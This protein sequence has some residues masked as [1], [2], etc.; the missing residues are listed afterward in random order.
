MAGNQPSCYPPPVDA[1]PAPIPE[2]LAAASDEEVMR[3]YSA[4]QMT[5]GIKRWAEIAATFPKVDAED[6]RRIAPGQFIPPDTSAIETWRKDTILLVRAERIAKAAI[7][8]WYA[9]KPIDFINHWGVTYDPRSAMRKGTTSYP[10]LLLFE[11][12]RDFV[13]F[14]WALLNGEEHALIEKSRDM[15]ATWVCALFSVWLWLTSSAAVGWGSRKEELVD[16]IGDPDSIFE[17]IRMAIRA[18]PDFL[19]PQGLSQ[20]DHLTFMKCINPD[21]GASITGECGDNIGRGGRSLI[22]FKDE[23]AHYARPDLIEASLGDNTNVQVDFSSVNGLGNVF[24]RRREAGEIWEPGQP[25]VSGKANVFILDWHDH[26]G[27]DEEWYCTRRDKAIREGLLHKFKQEVDRDYAASVEGLIIKAEW[28]KAAIDAHKKLGFDDSG[29]YSGGLDVSDGETGDTNALAIFKGVVL[30]AADDWGSVDTGAT[31]RRAVEQCRD[32][33]IDLQY[34]CIGVGSGVK[35]EANRLADTIGDDGLPLLPEGISLIPWSASA[36]VLDP[37]EPV[38]PDDRDSPTNKDMFLNLK[39]QAW[40]MVAR[41]FEKT[42]R[43][44]EEGIDYDPAELIS[45]DSTIPRVRQ[46]EK[47]LSQPTIK[48]HTNSGKMLIDKKP[49][50]TKS[51]NLGDAIIMA[52]FPLTGMKPI[53]TTAIPEFQMPPF[54]VPPFWPRAFAM[55]VEPGRTMALW[56]AYDTGQRTLYVTTEHL[57][58]GADPAVNVAA[59]AARGQWIPGIIDSDETKIEARREMAQF[60]AALGIEVTLADRAF[61]AGV[62]DVNSLISTGRLKVFSSCQGTF[63]DYRAYRRNEEGAIV[64]GG[65][66]DCLRIL[67]RPA[68][69][70]NMRTKPK[71]EMVRMPINSGQGSHRGDVRTGY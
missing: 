27:K 46:I 29:T 52:A 35:A 67:C 57:R 16:R 22:Y 38:N 36:S 43:A 62:Q 28:V 8:S 64:G 41:R 20:A 34:D 14:L 71:T 56:A 68:T 44:I 6:W 19:L 53:F 48:R 50:G 17:K 1:S 2:R 30:R 31:T 5:R 58:S 10:P 21:T 13:T 7:L 12:Q 69:I 51:P 66:M 24:H 59:I 49:E 63:R 55:K 47:E 70:A 39:A 26:P 40:W 65:L 42:Y 33:D 37:D 54:P 11:R 3:L 61:E 23:S 25:L 32:L 60:Y 4:M 15:G 9:D 45:I 18:L